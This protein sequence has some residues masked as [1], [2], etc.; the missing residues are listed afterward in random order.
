[1]S[2]SELI[3][4][5]VKQVTETKGNKAKH[6]IVEAVKSETALKTFV[7]SVYANTNLY[8]SKI[9][10]DLAAPTMWDA[11]S[12]TRNWY[13][14]LHWFLEGERRG[15]GG[16]MRISQAFH[17]CISSADQELLKFIVQGDLKCGIG[18]KG[19]NKL[20]GDDTIFIPPYQRCSKLADNNHT[21]WDGIWAQTKEDAQFVNIIQCNGQVEFYSRNFNLIECDIL[22]KWGEE[23]LEHKAVGSETSTDVVYMGEIYV[24][25]ENGERYGREKSNGLING[26][27]QT[28]VRSEEFH[29]V[30]I[31]LWDCVP[32]GDFYAGK[33][34]IPYI[35]RY[36]A[37][38]L[39]VNEAPSLASSD[40]VNITMVETSVCESMDD[41]AK[42]FQE[43]LKAE[44]EGLVIKNPDGIWETSGGHRDLV[45]IKIPML[46]RMRVVG[47]NE[48]DSTSR[49]HNTFG[50]IQMESEDGRVISA[51]SGMTD[52]MR[53]K[54][55]NNREDYIGK[56]F[57]CKCNGIQWNPQEPHSLYYLNFK[58]E[59]IDVDTAHTFEDIKGIMDSAIE[60]L[61][62]V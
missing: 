10:E 52:E 48:A 35:K 21:Q 17:S 46:V 18:A 49:H 8:Q 43:V 56:I 59:R 3:L 12:K 19:W 36:F 9:N 58:A 26:V 42:I 1:M 37:T 13:E 15:D 45:K 33:C 31:V 16:A 53:K 25:D 11:V 44:G 50:S 61:K 14:A 24:T 30:D 29:G 54:I 40:K 41:V 22:T 20:L 28:G 60:Q 34:H 51:M 23:F 6:A 38:E 57:E 39:L 55:H 47:Y 62:M 27:I 32:V 5:T 7:S 4:S 2:V